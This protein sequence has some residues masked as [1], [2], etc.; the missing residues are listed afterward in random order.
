MTH[1]GGQT[2]GVIQNPFVQIARMSVQGQRLIGDRLDHFWMGMADVRDVV[3]TI[4]K[5][6]A[7]GV[8]DPRPLAFY[9][10]HGIL[11]KGGHIG[12]KKTLTTGKDGG[13]I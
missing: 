5:P 7:V 12:S 1:G 6:V 3:V 2:V 10:M 9:Q 8:P 4:Q 13:N 11:I